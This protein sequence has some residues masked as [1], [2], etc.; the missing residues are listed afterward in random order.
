MPN[1]YEIAEESL[2]INAFLEANEGELT[3][4]IEQRIDALMVE[5]PH[6]LE[7]AAMVVRNL[8][9]FEEECAAESRRF[10]ERARS[11]ANNA[12]RLKDRMTMAL[13]LAFNGKIKTAKFTIWTQ[14]SPDT[15]AVDLREEFTL[16]MLKEDHP[17]LVRTKLELDKN[18][19]KEV[20]DR[21]DELPES[22]FVEHNIGTRYTRIK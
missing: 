19:C 11:F 15:T 1:L 10:A 8:E 3:P 4:E 2:L 14:K 18:A 6:K 12:K 13:D 9:A 22:I 21:G 17:E 20:L 16:E 7:A 5:G